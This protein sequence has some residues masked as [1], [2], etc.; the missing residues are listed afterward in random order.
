MQELDYLNVINTWTSNV[1]ADSSTFE[2][3]HHKL[4]I[5]VEVTQEI[6]D[7][8]NALYK[9]SN[10][11]NTIHSYDEDNYILHFAN[12]KINLSKKGQPTD[13]ALLVQVL[14]K[15]ESNE[16]M[17]NDEILEAWGVPFENQNNTPKNKVYKAAS[18]AN[19]KIQK[20]TGINDLIQFN[21]KQARINPKYKP[22][23]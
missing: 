2:L 18:T 21:T 9:Q 7:E 11:K 3:T 16:F 8:I 1:Y 4:H 20:A 10:P 5:N 14:I 23:E 19:D 15:A 22:D 13:A 17:A 6:I 12:H